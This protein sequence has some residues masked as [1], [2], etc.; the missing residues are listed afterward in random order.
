MRVTDKIEAT[1][2]A[3]WGAKYVD[4]ATHGD[5]V[6]QQYGR[7]QIWKRVVWAF[8]I[9]AL[10]LMFAPIGNTLHYIGW[11]VSTIGL[12]PLVCWLAERSK[13]RKAVKTATPA[14]AK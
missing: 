6:A 13:F 10:P 12:F 5:D 4:R 3:R 9:V 2:A 7:A 11:L 8:Y 14:S 1:G